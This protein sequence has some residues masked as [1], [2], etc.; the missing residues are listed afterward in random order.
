MI[1]RASSQEKMTLPS[2]ATA[3]CTFLLFVLTAAS[4]QAQAIT[5]APAPVVEAPLLPAQSDSNGVN[6]LDGSISFSHTI[7]LGPKG[8][9]VEYTLVYNSTSATTDEAGWKDSTVGSMGCFIDNN[10]MYQKSWATIDGSTEFIDSGDSE[11]IASDEPLPSSRPQAPGSGSINEFVYTRGDGTVVEYESDL[12]YWYPGEYGCARSDTV[13]RILRPDGEI[14]TY[15][16]GTGYPV[17][18]ITIVSSLGYQV[19][20]SSVPYGSISVQRNCVV[21]YRAQ[22]GSY[23]RCVSSVVL[24]DTSVDNCDPVGPCAYTRSWPTLTVNYPGINTLQIVDSLNRATTYTS[25]GQDLGGY[26]T[27]RLVSRVQGPDGRDRHIS[28]LPSSGGPSNTWKKGQVETVVEGSATWSYAYAISNNFAGRFVGSISATDPTGRVTVY[29]SGARWV[30]AFDLPQPYL[31]SVTRPGN[32]TTSYTWYGYHRPRP[33][34]IT[35]PSGSAVSYAY[36]ER[37]NLTSISRLPVGGGAPIQVTLGYDATCGNVFTCNQPNYRIDERGNRTDFTYHPSHGALM[38]VLG[39]A[40]GSGPYATVRP[41]TSY[42]YDGG[43]LGIVRSIRTRTCAT[44]QACVGS[45]NESVVETL[46]DAKRRPIR[47]GSRA[48][49]WTQTTMSGADARSSV[50][51]MTYTPFGDVATVDGPLAGD[52]DTTR[53]YHDAG[54]QL[55]ATVSP[56]PDGAGALPRLVGR[57]VYDGGGRQ[58]RVETGTATAADG[59]DFSL[60]RFSRSTYDPSGLLIKVEEVIP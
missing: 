35:S 12:Y 39:P 31:A 7:S 54:R 30:P 55:V 29:R 60:T 36:D 19:R 46:Y 21:F 37:H 16:Y 4:A 42:E 52:A 5:P 34:T 13:K 44:A 38:T 32:E 57:F 8:G 10:A 56:D 22:F 28:Y 11:R 20:I 3:A 40:A 9:G 48:G 24:V 50:S 17:T 18:L 27:R 14:L 51:T 41:Q 1:C 6:V 15:H 45:A 49:D 53:M 58:I 47:I 25:I 2:M 26:Y 33:K 43:S 59:S 23:P